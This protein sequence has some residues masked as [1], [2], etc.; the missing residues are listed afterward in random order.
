MHKLIRSILFF[1]LVSLEVFSQGICPTVTI[2]STPTVSC[3]GSSDGSATAVVTGGTGNFTYSWSNGSN[4]PSIN[5]LSPGIYYINVID[6]GNGCNVFDLAIIDEPDQ[7]TVSTSI[8][9]V[10]CFGLSTGK[11]DLT[12][13]GGTK[14]YTYSWSNG[15]SSEDL[16][17]IPAGNYSV[18]VT[19]ANGCSESFSTVVKQP[20]TPLGATI[21]G[22][23]PACRGNFNGSVTLQVF[24]GT[25]AYDFNWNSGAYLTQNLSNLPAGTYSVVIRD[26]NDCTVNKSVTLNDPQ[27]LSSSF[28]KQ[29]VSCYGE[30]DGSID[31]TVNG[32]TTP[33]TYDWTNSTY[34]LSFATQDLINLP[35][36]DYTVVIEDSRGCT[37]TNTVSITEPLSPVSATFTIQNVSCFGDSDGSVTA[38]AT[39]GTMPYT[40]SWSNGTNNATISN[41][42]AGTYIVTITDNSGCTFIDSAEVTQPSAPLALSLSVTNV[43]CA[44]G[45]DGAI[46]LTV[47]GGTTPY[48]YNWNS[49]TFT[50]ENLSNI[51][52]GNYD[53]IVTDSKN[54]TANANAVITEPNPLIVLDTIIDVD[55][56]G[57]NTG[58]ILLGVS[59]GTTPYSYQW[60]SSSFSLGSSTQDLSN[61]FAD[62]YYLELTDGNNCVYIDSFTVGQ[63]AALG[64]SV[65]ITD[66]Q[67]HGD[68]DGAID[69]SVNGGVLPYSYQ[70]SNNGQG[71]LPDTTQDLNNIPADEYQVTVTD[72][73]NC[74][75]QQ[76]AIV[77]QPQSPLTSTLTSTNVSC[78]GGN[79]GTATLTVS[80]GTAPYTVTWSNGSPLQNQNN[81]FAGTYTVLIVDANGCQ[82]NNQVTITQPNAPLQSSFLITH[83][84]CFG[85]ENGQV[86]TTITGGTAPYSYSW[87]NSDY[88]LSESSKNLVDFPADVYLLTTTDA[89]GCVLI[90]TVEI[91]QP[92]LLELELIKTDILCFG[93]SSG[94]INLTVTGGVQPYLYNW[95]NGA[96]SED[97]NNIGSGWYSV[98]VTDANNCIKVDSAF[99]SQP[100]EALSF[101]K[102]VTK[103][104]CFGSS[105]GRIIFLPIGGTAPYDFVWSNGDSTSIVSN[106]K[107]GYYQVTLTDA[108]GCTLF[109]SVF[110]PQPDKIIINDSINP[111]ICYGENSGDIILTITGG[112]DP[113]S[114]RWANSD[115]QLNLFSKDLLNIPTET[116]TVDLTD[117]NNCKTS[118][119]FFVPEPDTLLP[120]AEIKYITCAGY[121]DGGVG[122]YPSGGNPPY[123]YSW[124]I[125]TADSIISDLDV[126]L[127]VYTITDR[128]GCI[129][130]DSI[131]LTDP[132]TLRFNPDVVAV[133]CIDQVDGSITL[134][135][136]G[137]YGNYTFEWSNGD[138]GNPLIDIPGGDYTVTITDYVGCSR[139]SLIILPVNQE[140]CLFIPNSFTPNN[141]GR[142]DTWII[143]NM[144]L[145]PNVVVTIFNRWGNQ[146]YQSKGYSDPWNGNHKSGRTLPSDTYYYVIDVNNGTTPKSGSVTIV[147]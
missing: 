135:P 100:T 16:N 44:Q 41:L 20:N 87:V 92:P 22:T 118:A 109:D 104:K 115:F 73:N 23:N 70:W 102:E 74:T 32:G 98:T 145:Y 25:P 28:T 34:D 13:N 121:A 29:D 147:R 75:I 99:I 125:N 83:V 103:T 139:D 47:I 122:L 54:C 53:I 141:D 110:V 78:F 107:S 57:N 143:E 124:N 17:N 93:D 116:Y 18:T 71:T 14:P 46:D 133:S 64:T 21:S 105:D 84:L 52:A 56:F 68:S 76:S 4:N 51:F 140:E 137:G 94:A 24:G 19:D 144:Y 113:Y 2:N 9:D 86:V 1:L 43:S 62:N 120:N 128:R 123:N 82:A 65:V 15:S 79:D 111:V 138:F 114:Y 72:F 142:N 42:I 90:D 89:K 26:D 38:N 60:N 35:A 11:I 10:L 101:D 7:L 33:F 8:T 132:D 81:L 96:Q 119:S 127:Y 59:G 130:Q 55:C 50:T 126:G 49:G 88:V 31:L 66:V 36:D 77:S 45:N 108:N 61:I 37:S 146:V 63:P 112:T 80:G 69:L 30:T 5:F 134:N 131:N 39:G 117:S 40:Y 136:A 106:I 97:L 3:F 85:E 48:Q 67:C 129:N 6:Q 91:E 12:V 95:S 27:V 58:A